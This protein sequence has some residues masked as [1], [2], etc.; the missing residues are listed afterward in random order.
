M[1]YVKTVSLNRLRKHARI[2]ASMPFSKHEAKKTSVW[3]VESTFIDLE[4]IKDELRA[5]LTDE[6]GKPVLTMT[7]STLRAIHRKHGIRAMIQAQINMRSSHRTRESRAVRASNK[8]SPAV[9]FAQ[10]DLFLS[11]KSPKAY[12][13]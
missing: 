6:I 4:T 9:Q 8:P 11:N 2:C 12:S 5:I 13:G 1:E 10:R 7:L 3:I